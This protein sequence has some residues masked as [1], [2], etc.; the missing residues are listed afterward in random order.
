MLRA[1]PRRHRVN[2]AARPPHR[3]LG[4]TLLAGLLVGFALLAPSAYG[5][6]RPA[7]FLRIPVEAVVG[8]LLVLVLPRR[9]RRV[10]VAVA[11]VVLGLL[12]LLKLLF[13]GFTAVLGRPFDLVLDWGFFSNGFD[14]LEAA[15]PK[16]VAVAVVVGVVV[17][18]CAVPLVMVLS[19]QRLS[20]VVV[21]HPAPA[22]RCIAVAGVGWVVCSL[23]GLQ[24]APGE[25]VAASTTVHLVRDAGSR[26]RSSLN[27]RAV[28]RREEAAD[29]RRPAAGDQVLGALKGK[30]VV[31]AFVESYGRSAIE[32]PRIAPG[33]HSVLD[34][35]NA[36]LAADG[37]S[38]ASGWLGSPTVGA[39]SWLAHSTL[40]SGLKV[41]NQERYDTLLKSDRLTL[42]SAFRTAGWRTIG[43][44]PATH[45]PWPE[46]AFYH[47]QRVYERD[48]LGYKGPKFGWS[49]MPDQFALAAL[50]KDQLGVPGRPPAMAV[51]ELTSS[52]NPWVPLPTMVPWNGLGDGSVFGPIARAGKKRDQVWSNPNSVRTEYGRS[53]QYSLTALFSFLETYGTPN[54]VLV[55]L[56]D[57]Q[58]SPL[59]TGGGAS[60]DV[61]IT[62]VAKDP[63]VLSR[64]SGWGWQQGLTPGPTAPEWPMEAFRDRFLSAFSSPSR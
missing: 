44:M 16:A 6:L 42:S 63:T 28:F 22:A 15:V 11:G 4:W 13:L 24:S 2:P 27:D 52:H 5:E 51:T 34:A 36:R 64:I 17:L 53:I 43:F 32:D 30:D 33:V 46:G 39:G 55:F 20:N 56:G 26:V 19:L 3:W 48:D 62:I 60:R 8:A 23:L 35:G 41:A 25:P 10:V 54:T 7:A 61:P 47:Y 40:L 50:Q 12:L 37:F 49:T 57:H 1:A 59:V 29:S 9:V 18:A 38:S 31:I 45:G 58:P 14:F 21:R